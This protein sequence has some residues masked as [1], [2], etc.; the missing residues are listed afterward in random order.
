MPEPAQYSRKSG[1]LGARRLLGRVRRV[2][3]IGCPAGSQ[4]D[5][6]TRHNRP[7]TKPKPPSHL[8]PHSL[9]LSYRRGR[10]DHFVNVCPRIARREIMPDRREYRQS[11][12]RP[13]PLLRRR[14]LGP[15]RG[16]SP[17]ATSPLYSSPTRVLGGAIAVSGTA[18]AALGRGRGGLPAAFRGLRRRG[19][20]LQLRH[21]VFEFS[22][23]RGGCGMARPAGLFIL[24]AQLYI[25]ALQFLDLG[26]QF[27]LAEFRDRRSNC[28]R[29]F[30]S[31]RL[32]RA[33]GQPGP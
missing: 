27:I 2:V 20:F 5:E 3:E 22:D 16:S 21:L 8:L 32:F 6:R 10:R 30:G 24:F 4:S 26:A 11:S 29:A 23:P 14:G 18:P 19:A 31:G 7:T 25:C 9:E 17:R 13:L 33:A 1:L 28:G 15:G 12:C